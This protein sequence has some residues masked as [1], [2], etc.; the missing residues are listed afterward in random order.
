MI[1]AG[2]FDAQPAAWFVDVRTEP[3]G[4]R[5]CGV[6]AETERSFGPDA[7]FAQRCQ[8]ESGARF[9]GGSYRRAFLNGGWTETFFPHWH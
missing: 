4:A 7:P 6:K 9:V 3:T 1:A 8:L 2:G 5:M